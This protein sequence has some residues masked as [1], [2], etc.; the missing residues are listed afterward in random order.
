VPD[1]SNKAVYGFSTGTLD[2]SGANSSMIPYWHMDGDTT[3]EFYIFNINGP[4]YSSLTFDRSKTALA[5]LT[6][7]QNELP[8]NS[9]A[10]RLYL[11]GGSGI[12]T[13]I[14]LSALR[15]L[16]TNLKVAR[17]VLEFQLDPSKINNLY[18]KSY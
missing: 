5:S 4:R 13:K 6:K 8:L 15:H 2:F 10:D 17:A 1:K 16:G 14:D 12:S 18:R 9:A 7:A 11:Q 3:S